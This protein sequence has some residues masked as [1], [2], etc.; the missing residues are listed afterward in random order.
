M[1][2]ENLSRYYIQCDPDDDV[3]AWTDAAFWSELK[4]RIPD[5]FADILVT[6]PTI[7]KNIT[8]V[9]SFV[10]EPMQYGSLFLCG[11]A[12][13]VFPPTGAKGLNTAASDVHYLFRGFREF[14]ETKSKGHLDSYSQVAL[15][16]VWK[17]QRF[18]KWFTHLLHKDTN[19]FDGDE[20]AR[21][22]ALRDLF[23]ST[24]TQHAFAQDYVGSPY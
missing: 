5:N 12:A 22:A 9:R 7:E 24:E 11:D 8:P 18:S 17:A 4:R 20:K 21:H 14:Y 1:R 3:N 10:V 6:G 16:R 13:H 2:N 15:A 19:G 23:E